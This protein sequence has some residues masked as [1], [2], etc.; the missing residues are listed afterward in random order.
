MESYTNT[1]STLAAPPRDASQTGIKTCTGAEAVMRCLIAEKTEL[2]F[3][4]PGGAIMPVYDALYDFQHQIRHILVRHEQG[5][6]HAAEGYARA[7][8]KTGVVFATSGPGA[9]NL[10]TGLADAL[11]DSVP[12]VCIVGQVH[13]SLLGT[14]AFQEAN[15]MSITRSVTKWSYQVTC[16]DEIP[17]IIAQAFHI[18]HKGRPGPVL[19]EITKDAQSGKLNNH[20]HYHKEKRKENN[21]ALYKE[22]LQL[23]TAAQLLQQAERPLILAGNGVHISGAQQEL[24]Q[25]AELL[26]IPVACT[27]HGLSSFPADHYLYAGMLGMHGNYAP[28]VLTNQADVILAIGMRFDD[29]VT[30][31]VSRYAR[32]AQIIHIEIDPSEINK[33]VQVSIALQG[34]ARQVLKALLPLLQ[35]S[36][37]EQWLSIFHSYHIIEREEVKKRILSYEDPQISMAHVIDQ[38]ST[39]SRGEA[40][41]VADVGQHQMIAAQYYNFLKSGSYFTS[42]G[43]GTMGFALPAAMGVQL[44]MPSRQ[45]IAIMGDGCFQMTIQELATIAQYAIPVKAI[46]LN[47]SYLGMVRQWQSLFFDN[48]YSSVSMHNPDFA[49]ITNAFGIPALNVN[50]SDELRPALETMLSTRGPFL[51]NIKVAQEHNVFPMIPPGAA[52]DEVRLK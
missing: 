7:T 4:Y 18:A 43:L 24:L 5:A 32:Q 46:I 3:G 40:L 8:G 42:G 51:L 28:N 49:A 45:V 29:R 23:Q 16:A 12:L 14:D 22:N 35:Q 38:L 13:S 50:H 19:I 2:V 52:V 25:L 34:D 15:I 37:H 33:I 36:R 1:P 47:N 48:R 41:L 39:L 6:I 26:E 44:G 30:G 27:L 9:T 20:F 10:V 11:M 31:D 21:P 17:G